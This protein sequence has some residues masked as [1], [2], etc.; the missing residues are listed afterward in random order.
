M[1]VMVVVGELAQFFLD[2]ITEKRERLF[3]PLAPP[4]SRFTVMVKRGR[5]FYVT[6]SEERLY[7]K[8]TE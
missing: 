4:R 5:G 6:F 8:N 2:C 3:A 7:S 1:G